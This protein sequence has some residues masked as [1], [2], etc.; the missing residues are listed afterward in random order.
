MFDYYVLFVCL[1][2]SLSVINCWLV[3][4]VDLLVVIECLSWACVF[5]CFD[6]LVYMCICIILKCGCSLYYVLL[7][8]VLN[9]FDRVCY[10]WCYVSQRFN[11]FLGVRLHEDVELM[12]WLICLRW[13]V[14]LSFDSVFYVVVQPFVMCVV[15]CPGCASSWRCT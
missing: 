10:L 8:Y 13:C 3:Y 6:C 9:K 1:L 4:C 14:M 2:F 5:M 12:C 11:A 7:V 15:V